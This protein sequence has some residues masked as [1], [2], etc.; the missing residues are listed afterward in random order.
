MS[1]SPFSEEVKYDPK[2]AKE[3]FDR[4]GY[5]ALPGFLDQGEV[6]ALMEELG[7]YIREVVPTL[8]PTEVKYEDKS[9]LDSL[10][11]LH[12]LAAHDQFFMAMYAEGKFKQL[13]DTLLGEAKVTGNMQYFDKPPGVNKPT[14]AH[15]DGYYFMIEPC[16]G[17]TMWLA[18]DDVDEE[19]G[20]VRYVTGSHRKGM[21]EHA[22]SGILGFSQS[23]VDFGRDDDVSNEVAMPASPGDLLV[24]HALTIHRAEGNSSTSRHRRSMGLIYYAAN[25]SENTEAREA[26][27]KKLDDQLTA[28]GRI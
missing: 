1:D 20:C 4:D 16:E 2:E 15:Q 13:A 5:V 6:A 12:R 9:N 11:Q 23:M 18:L 26:Y 17:L 10:K 21:R 25:A 7:R 8:D 3:R 24:H 22:E 27:R 14:P 28:S 19:N